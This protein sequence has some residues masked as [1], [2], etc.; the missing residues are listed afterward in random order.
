MKFRWRK[1]VLNHLNIIEIQASD[2]DRY[3]NSG[4][5]QS[6]A[7]DPEFPA[8]P[9]TTSSTDFKSYDHWLQPVLTDWQAYEHTPLWFLSTF[10]GPPK[11]S[12]QDVEHGE[13]KCRTTRTMLEDR[14]RL[15]R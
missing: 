8:G 5:K 14:R 3:I 4:S 13:W 7:T 10:T 2:F 1:E 15:G 9:D 6:T 12:D 11:D